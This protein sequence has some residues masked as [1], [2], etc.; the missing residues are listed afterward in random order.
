MHRHGFLPSDSAKE[1]QLPL[2]EM[3]S[4]DMSVQFIV[5][6]PLYAFVAWS[7]Y[8]QLKIGHQALVQAPAGCEPGGSHGREPLG[9]TLRPCGGRA[10]RCL[11]LLPA[12]GDGWAA[13]DAVQHWSLGHRSGGRKAFHGEKGGQ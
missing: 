10:R 13:A 7:S 4:V 12:G 8:V 1:K 3:L 11:A 6:A 2:G 9:G 5:V